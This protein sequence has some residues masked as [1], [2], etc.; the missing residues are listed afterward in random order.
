MAGYG[1][2][3]ATEKSKQ[4]IAC[5][6]EARP[7][8]QARL[9]ELSALADAGAIL[10]AKQIQAELSMMAIDPDRPDGVRLKAIDQLSKTKGMYTDNIKVETSGQLSIEDK[11]AYMQSLLNGT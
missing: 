3:N 9:K 8:I 4:E 11:R 2:G 1:R 5:R 7:D 6:I 10:D